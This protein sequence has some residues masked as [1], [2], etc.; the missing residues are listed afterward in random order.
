MKDAE[1]LTELDVKLKDVP[2]QVQSVE[3][4]IKTSGKKKYWSIC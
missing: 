2:E 1:N 3:I 4:T